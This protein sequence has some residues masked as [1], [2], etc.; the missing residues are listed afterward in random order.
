MLVELSKVEIA[1]VG[2]AELKVSGGFAG[3]GIGGGAGW[4]SGTFGAD[5]S[6]LGSLLPGLGRSKSVV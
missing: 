4:V 5:G 6:T 1:Q 2:G 3:G